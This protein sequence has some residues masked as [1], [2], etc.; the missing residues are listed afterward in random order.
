MNYDRKSEN[1][2]DENGNKTLSVYYS[3]NYVTQKWVGYSK[4]EFKFDSNNKEILSRNYNWNDSTGQWIVSSQTEKTY[5]N[6]GNVVSN[7]QYTK[8]YKEITTYNSSND[9]VALE[10][11]NW[12]VSTKE[13]DGNFKSEYG[14]DTLILSS[15]LG[16]PFLVKYKM[17][18]LIT[19]SW[20]NNDWDLGTNFV[21]YY[22]DEPTGLFQN[23]FQN[24]S[25]VLFPNPCKDFISLKDNMDLYIG[26]EILNLSGTLIESNKGI[27]Q[28]I[29]T[30]NLSSGTYILKMRNATG[31][32]AM[33]FI[34]E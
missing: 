9:L 11:Y 1:E 19:N 28:S 24:L 26:Y 31:A 32:K 17:T 18:K 34:K 8:S 23:Q 3:W 22:S 27:F 12:N 10:S 30:S 21:F 15:N 25:S 29:A 4:E 5:N 13:W 16:T 2:Y 20:L 33:K 14:Y 7:S 6:A